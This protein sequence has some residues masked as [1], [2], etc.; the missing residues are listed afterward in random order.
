MPSSGQT[1]ATSSS[2]RVG[3][4]RALSAL[5]RYLRGG[6]RSS[7]HAR[8]YLERLGVAPA[9]Q[10]QLLAR[11]EAQGLIDDQLAVR[12]LAE[13]WARRGQA[14]VLIR[15]HLLEKGFDEDTVDRASRRL[16]LPTGDLQRARALTDAALRRSAAGRAAAG[17]LRPRARLERLLAS[18]GFDE[19][20][21]ERVV[22]ERLGSDLSDAEH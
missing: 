15:H 9:A 10:A 3:D 14:W 16:G 13:H 11:C 22:R 20:L 7:N 4:S 8:A 12:L 5:Q 21:I 1:G 6:I 17:R 19:E 2:K 18:R